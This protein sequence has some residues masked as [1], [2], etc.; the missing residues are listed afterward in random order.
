MDAIVWD[1]DGTLVD[2]EP[3][4][5]IATF[6]LAEHLGAPLTAEKRQETIG[7]SFSN[8][9]RVCATNASVTPTR[10]LE[11]T[12]YAWMVDRMGQ[13]FAEHLH[14]DDGIVRLL[15]SIHRAGIPMAVATNTPRVLAQPALDALGEELFATT[16]C[17]DEVAH[18]KPAPDMYLEAVTRLGAT[19][20][21]TLVFEDST[22]GM[23]A[24][25]A[26][27]CTVIGLPADE[28]TTV[29]DGV[30]TIGQLTGTPPQGNAVLAASSLDEI[31]DWFTRL[32][33][34]RG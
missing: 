26:A 13:L 22:T 24:A 2:S 8:T 18:G 5:S 20:A 12:W 19:A 4:W 16:I 32:R 31:T 10:E 17:G 30:T 6:E 25:V 27:G 14:V 3:I 23:A 15:D 28:H 21:D 7:G 11:Q 33:G 34:A 9:F 29:A 1:M